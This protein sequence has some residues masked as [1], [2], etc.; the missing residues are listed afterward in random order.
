MVCRFGIVGCLGEM[1][2]LKWLR[3]MVEVCG[4]HGGELTTTKIKFQKLNNLQGSFKR[5]NLIGRGGMKV[6]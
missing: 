6:W 5:K 4:E 1:V 3:K 2:V